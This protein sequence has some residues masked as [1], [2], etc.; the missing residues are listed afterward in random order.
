MLLELLTL[1]P[2]LTEKRRIPMKR[3]DV[4]MAV[5]GLLLGLISNVALATPIPV[6]AV[7]ASST[8]DAVLMPAERTIDGSGLSGTFPN[9]THGVAY[10]TMWMTANGDV[11]DASIQF[12]LGAAYNLA[13]AHIWNY[14]QYTVIV[15]VGSF[16]LTNRG[17]QQVDIFV[18]LDSASWTLF[19]D[20]VIFPR[21]PNTPTPSS[22]YVGFDLDLGGTLARYVKFE[23]DSNYGIDSGGTAIGNYVGLSEVQ[24]TPAPVPE[25]ATMFLLGSGLIGVGAFVRRK[26]KR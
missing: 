20:D 15:D 24:F 4:I 19:D 7:T 22:D 23:I 18:S 21:A 11:A 26:F 12:D 16:D 6:S 17:I 13:S 1:I 10:E 14:N 8:W 3:L 9:Q 25:P 2:G 5:L